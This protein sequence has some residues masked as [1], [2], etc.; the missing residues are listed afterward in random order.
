MEAAQKVLKFTKMCEDSN[1]SSLTLFISIFF[2]ENV[3]PTVRK[4]VHPN[5]ISPTSLSSKPDQTLDL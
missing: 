3:L 2:F 4:G 5:P 1:G